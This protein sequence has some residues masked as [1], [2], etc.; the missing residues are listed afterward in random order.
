MPGGLRLARD[1]ADFLAQN[2]IEQSRFADVGAAHDCDV[3]RAVRRLL[4][5][6][7]G[8]AVNAFCAAACSATRRL[9][10]SPRGRT[11]SSAITHSTSK[12]W[13]WA[14]PRVATT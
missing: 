4:R 9:A 11:L 8:N 3:A 1:N 2:C 14:W 10:P 6:H 13:A 5:A 12:R 7:A